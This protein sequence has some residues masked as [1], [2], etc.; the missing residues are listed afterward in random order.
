MMTISQRWFIWVLA[1][2][3][4]VPA[5]EARRKSAKAGSKKDNVYSD[6][7]YGFSFTIHEN[8]NAKIK[9]KKNP[10]RLFMF[11]KNYGVTTE[12]RLTP[13]YN[14]NPKVVLYIDTT[15]MG[16]RALVDSLASDSYKSKQKKTILKEFEFLFEPEL[17]PRG[18]R[19]FQVKGAKGVRWDGQAKYVKEIQIS[20]N[21]AAGK[22]VYGT[23]S[24]AI[25]GVK[26]GNVIA[27]F[28]VMTERE[29]FDKV[30]LEV[31]EMINSI[32]WADSDEDD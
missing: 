21:T 23:Y 20:T 1:L 29:F 28:H 30:M 8:W 18:R 13:D 17:K 7:T 4:M 26:N 6:A 25:I 24:G 11:Q 12:Y 15:S 27:L 31:M 32:K 3:L 14:K 10:F 22:R 2:L 9:K 19:M 16:P 5:V